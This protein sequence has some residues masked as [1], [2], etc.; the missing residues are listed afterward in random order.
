MPPYKKTTALGRSDM[1]QRYLMNTVSSTVPAATHLPA[2]AETDVDAALRK[3]RWICCMRL[4]QR[5]LVVLVTVTVGATCR[6][7]H[8]GHGVKD[9]VIPWSQNLLSGSRRRSYQLRIPHGAGLMSKAALPGAGSGR[10]LGDG[11]AMWYV[12]TGGK[13]RLTLPRPEV[14]TSPPELVAA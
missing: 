2:A 4:Y 7:I 9:G 3:R 6:L 12:R 5:W 10:S 14:P 11:R 1:T 13:R 8:A